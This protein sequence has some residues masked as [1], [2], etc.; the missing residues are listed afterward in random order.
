[1]AQWIAKSFNW[2]ESGKLALTAVGFALVFRLVEP[3]HVPSL[4]AGFCSV[5]VLQWFIAIRI[6]KRSS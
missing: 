1:M 6:T 5:L 3:L 4:F 2:G